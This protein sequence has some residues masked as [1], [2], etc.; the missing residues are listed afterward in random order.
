MAR[1]RLRIDLVPELGPHGAI[2]PGKIALLE[3]IRK[4]RS[5]TKAAKACGMSYTRA[6]SL[7]EAING[8]FR[9]PA[10]LAGAGGAGGGGA[11]LTALGESVL[12][13]YKAIEKSATKKF[14]AQLTV[15][16]AVAAPSDTSDRILE[17]WYHENPS[18][19]PRKKVLWPGKRE[20]GLPRLNVPP[21]KKRDEDDY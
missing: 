16:E 5:I 12:E 2:G 15:L 21:L 11:E 3:A 19:K 8:C 17:D 20:R 1:L 10:V 4:T 13:L 7:I 18:K 9:K 14:H 6:W